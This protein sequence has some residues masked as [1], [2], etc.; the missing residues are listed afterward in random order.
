MMRMCVSAVFDHKYKYVCYETSS[1]TQTEKDKNHP[2]IISR[3]KSIDSYERTNTSNE[4]AKPK[5]LSS[6]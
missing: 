2:L 6:S 3:E 5:Q 4:Y 1:S